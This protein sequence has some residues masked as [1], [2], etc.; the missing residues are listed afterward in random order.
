MADLPDGISVSLTQQAPVFLDIKLDCPAGSLLAL[1]GPSGSGKSTVLRS[2]AGLSHSASG[3]I[4]CNGERW[5]DTDRSIAKPARHRRVGFVFQDY[6]LFPHMTV[7]DNVRTSL[8][9]LSRRQQRSEATQVLKRV[10]MEGMEDRLPATLSGGQKQRVALARALARNPSVLLLDEPFSA[11]D[12]QTRERLY[13]ELSELRAG[14][15]IPAILVTHDISEVM[16]LADRIA[17]IKRGVTIQSG[18]LRE[19]LEK[20]NSI[21]AA[22]LVGQ[23]NLFAAKVMALQ[24][25]SIEIELFESRLTIDC[26]AIKSQ[27]V[28]NLSES[29]LPY[30]IPA[31][32]RFLPAPGQTITVMIPQSAVILHRQD[33][34]SRGERENPVSGV[35]EST[36]TLGDDLLVRLRV[37]HEIPV[38]AFRISRHVA[39]RN[40]VS[41]G[42]TVTV[43]LLSN[44]LHFIDET[45]N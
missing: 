3:S 2:I 19:V 43:S 36:I 17:L 15:G 23:Q 29:P 20:P 9:Y 5:L 8:S 34:P 14:L 10:N 1:T 35:V 28:T 38:L 27:T 25:N 37:T 13:L 44:E 4:V 18:L 40:D 31:E 42:N 39:S 6:G 12:Q 21:A 30:T 11:V 22:R 33:R 16:Q 45:M 26:A 24:E 41:A 7:L 32:N